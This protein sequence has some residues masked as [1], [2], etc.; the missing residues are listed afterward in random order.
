MRAPL[1]R[2]H[3]ASSD[4][5]LSNTRPTKTTLSANEISRGRYGGA[6][7]LVTGATGLIGSRL[8]HRLLE[9]AAEVHAL[10]LPEVE[11]QSE[12]VR[13]GD[14]QRLTVHGGRLESQPSVE[15]AVRATAPEFVFHLGAQSLVGVA[16]GDP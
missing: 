6:R 12:L 2:Q 13:S 15:E 1:I 16:R 4:Q 9:E 5:I 3:R 10:I 14:L 8:V 7:V 11:E